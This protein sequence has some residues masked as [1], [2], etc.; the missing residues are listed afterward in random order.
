MTVRTAELLVAVALAVLS[1]GIMIKSTDGLSI[2]WVPDAGPG[3][4][5]WPFWLSTGMLL[6]CLLTIVRWFRR[7]SPGSR[8]DE[9]FMTA[10]T[11]QIVGITVAALSLLLIGTHFIGIY[12]SM[13]LF[14]IFYLRILG[15]HGWLLTLALAL[16][17]P[18]GL[19]FFFEGALVIPLPKAYSEP[20]FYP[21]YD[22]IY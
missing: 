8:S 2:G 5:A 10:E 4:G 22:I 1:I 14:L 21:L 17:T 9:L 12:F 18:I 15:G 3:S 13:M 11:T 6:S 7:I 20:L 16:A 19:F